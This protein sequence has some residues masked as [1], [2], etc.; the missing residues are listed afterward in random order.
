MPGPSSAVP[1]LPLTVA[2]RAGCERARAV[3]DHRPHHLGHVVGDVLGDDPPRLARR[4]W[5]RAGERAIHGG[6][7]TPRLAIT[8]PTD[9]ICSG[10]AE[11]PPW[12]MPA[13]PRLTRVLERALRR[14]HALVQ[15]VGHVRA[16][17]E[18]ERH[19]RVAPAACRRWRRRPAR[20]PSCSSGQTPAPACRRTARGGS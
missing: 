12:P 19:R 14:H 6:R 18:P 13:T 11:T 5:M 3:G 7:S 17:V 16:G 9:A 20:T 10:V 2:M 4:S 1:V 8:C 15:R